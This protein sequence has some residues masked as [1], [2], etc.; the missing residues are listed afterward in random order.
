MINCQKQKVNNRRAQRVSMTQRKQSRIMSSIKTTNIFILSVT[1][2]SYNELQISLL[3]RRWGLILIFGN[4]GVGSPLSLNLLPPKNLNLTTS[5]QQLTLL[6]VISA[7][8]GKKQYGYSNNFKKL[9][10]YS[11]SIKRS[12]SAHLFLSYSSIKHLMKLL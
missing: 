4:R 1:D 3:G 2:Q 12:G 7:R 5:E 10:T 8:P 11:I 6:T 9:Q